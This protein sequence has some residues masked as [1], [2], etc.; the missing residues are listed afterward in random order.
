MIL[1]LMVICLLISFFFF[2][3]GAKP[4]QVRELMNVDGL[5]CD[6]VKSHL[7]VDTFLS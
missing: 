7:Q 1:C 2:S 4:K 6:E 5:T 3:T